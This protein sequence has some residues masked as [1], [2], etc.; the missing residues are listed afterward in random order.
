[1][2]PD[3]EGYWTLPSG[4]LPDQQDIMHI[5]AGRIVHLVTIENEPLKRIPMILWFEAQSEDTFIVRNRPKSVAWT[6]AMRRDGADLMIVNRKQVFR[7]LRLPDSGVPAWFQTELDHAYIKMDSIEKQ[8]IESASQ[9]Q[10]SQK[11]PLN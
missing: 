11:T 9:A 1:M 10:G 3:I 6:V 5:Q 2:K 7:C 4:I 8:I